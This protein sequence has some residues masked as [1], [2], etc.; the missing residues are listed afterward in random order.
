MIGVEAPE[1]GTHT[2]TRAHTHPHVHA[3]A[4]LDGETQNR[5]TMD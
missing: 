3:L 1:E 2:R 4:G 5:T